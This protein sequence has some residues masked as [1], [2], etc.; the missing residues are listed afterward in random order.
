MARLQC[1]FLFVAIAFGVQ[2]S[3]FVK[4]YPHGAP[5][6]AC[7]DMTPGH[8]YPPQDPT[9]NPYFLEVSAA[10]VTGGQEITSKTDSTYK[11]K[12]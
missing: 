6:E 3:G 10:S 11:L 4:A 9:T 8:G 1:I 12:N 2:L 5:V 7:A